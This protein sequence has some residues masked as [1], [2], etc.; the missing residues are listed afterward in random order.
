[1]N[2]W[3]EDVCDKV[4]TELGFSTALSHIY[5]SWNLLVR[6]FISCFLCA[7]LLL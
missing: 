2:D 6:H 7:A 1:M 5:F 4:E 3:V